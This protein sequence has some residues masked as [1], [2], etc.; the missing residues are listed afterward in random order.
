MNQQ[1]RIT[2]SLVYKD[3][4]RWDAHFS[5]RGWLSKRFFIINHAVFSPR[6]RLVFW[7]RMAQLFRELHLRIAYNITAMIHRNNQLRTGIQ[8]GINT[9]VGGGLVFPHYGS[10]VVTGYTR[11]GENATIFQQTT[12]G[13]VQGSKNTGAPII[14]SNVVVSAGAIVIGHI[15]IGDSVCIGAG[16]VVVKDVPDN[17]VVVGNPARVISM[18]AERIVRC[19][20]NA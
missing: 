11:I 18:D 16:A 1:I 3:T 17:A 12:I 14:G 19:Y 20:L 13:V 9:L 2:K 8:L 7:F 10:I 5:E 4:L 15:T 6:Y